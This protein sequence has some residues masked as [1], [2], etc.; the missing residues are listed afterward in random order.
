M[1]GVLGRSG[2][3]SRARALKTLKAGRRSRESRLIS[4]FLA[5]SLALLFE[6]EDGLSILE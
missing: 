5:S 3:M 1:M 4:S 2:E 6:F